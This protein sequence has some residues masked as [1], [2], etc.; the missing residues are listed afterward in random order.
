MSKNLD[1]KNPF[2]AA[3]PHDHEKSPPKHTREKK[4]G[5]ERERRRK[6]VRTKRKK[7]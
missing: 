5:Q 7:R 4:R 2:Y 1:S 3:S 6:K